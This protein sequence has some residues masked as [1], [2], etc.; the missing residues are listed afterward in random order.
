MVSLF[1]DLSDMNIGKVKEN[2]LLSKHT[3]MKVGG[4]ADCLVEPDSLKALE[5]II[6]Y[7]K[8]NDLPFRVIGRGS[9]LLMS[10][11]GIR[12]VVIK[13]GK[14]MN[15][16]T[17]N[18]TMVTVGAGYPLVPLATIISKKG[19]SGFEFAG[20]IPGSVGGAVYMNAGAHGSDIA[21]ILKKARILYPNGD[22]KWLDKA[23]MGFDYRTSILQ[24]EGGICVE[25]EFD[26]ETGNANEITESMQSYK[27]YRHSTQP[28]DM[29]CAGSIFRNPLPHHA[30]KLVDDAGLKGY[31]MGGAQIS[32]LHGNFIVNAGE[33]KANDVLALIEFIKNSIRNKYQVALHT[34][35]EIVKNN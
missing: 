23:D 27:D 16:L 19:L 30:G 20:G 7:V 13:L 29:P 17:I 26:L 35:I 28:Y 10:D 6:H 34:E 9:N 31:K 33:A 14:G 18:G 24:V 5:Q 15:E 22:L 25:A 4:P 1:E 32:E 8:S 21:A 11:E 2:E 3:T 12:G